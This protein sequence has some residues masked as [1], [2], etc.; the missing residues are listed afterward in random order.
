MDMSA[1]LA[2][3]LG[4][5]NLAAFFAFAFDKGRAMAGGRRVPERRLLALAAAGGSPG[6]LL[7]RRVLRHK[8][9]KQPFVGRLFAIVT[10]QAAVLAGLAWMAI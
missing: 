10:L 5:M 9:R 2:V 6:A 8:T 1:A 7:A 4:L 3:Y